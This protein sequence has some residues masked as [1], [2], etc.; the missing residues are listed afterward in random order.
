MGLFSW[1]GRGTKRPTVNPGPD[2]SGV[3]SRLPKGAKWGPGPDPA[4]DPLKFVPGR[5]NLYFDLVEWGWQDHLKSAALIRSPDGL[6]GFGFLFALSD[7]SVMDGAE[8]YS[9]TARG[10]QLRDRQKVEWVIPKRHPTRRVT[11]ISLGDPT[12]NLVRFLEKCFALPNS[13]L[14]AITAQSGINCA[15]VILQG[16]VVPD[17][18]LFTARCKFFLAPDGQEGD[19]RY[20]EF[21]LNINSVTKKLW[22]SE[23]A[24]AYRTPILNWVTGQAG[25]MPTN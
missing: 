21:F 7:G 6:M 17:T 3:Y 24:S 22:I 10:G 5:G 13:G 18:G 9:V 11:L 20:A 12:T 23:K 15:F 1:L 14:A 16:R 2:A 8:S 4:G 25:G 19:G